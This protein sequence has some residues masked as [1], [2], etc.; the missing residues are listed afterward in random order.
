MR[1]ELVAKIVLHSMAVVVGGLLAPF[2]RP[3]VMPFLKVAAPMFAMYFAI[4][5]CSPAHAF[6]IGSGVDLYTYFV[7]VRKA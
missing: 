2:L 7:F 4:T 6:I 5:Q 3:Y 1:D